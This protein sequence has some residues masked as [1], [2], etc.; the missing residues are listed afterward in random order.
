[1]TS[2]KAPS[3]TLVYYSPVGWEVSPDGNIGVAGVRM[4]DHMFF[5]DT[6]P[7]SSIF[8]QPLR[9]IDQRRAQIEGQK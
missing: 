2:T 5:L 6:D 8:R 4:G 3:G 1:V 9:F 7:S